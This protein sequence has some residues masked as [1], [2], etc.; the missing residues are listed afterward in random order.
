MDKLELSKLIDKRKSTREIAELLHTSQTNVRYW[1]RRYDL[2]TNPINMGRRKGP[3]KPLL[4]PKCG[5]TNPKKF[6][7]KRRNLCGKCHNQDVTK[8]GRQNIQYVLDSLGGKCIVCEF[9]DY[10]CALNIHHLDPIKKDKNFKYWRGWSKKRIDKEI[11]GCVLLC[12][13]C[14]AGVHGGFILVQNRV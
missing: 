4:C 14:H 8:R 13:N 7:G 12:S 2:Q 10:S 5:E 3:L 11:Q 9:D 6:Y 1:L